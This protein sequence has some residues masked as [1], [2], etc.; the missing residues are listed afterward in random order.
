MAFIIIVALAL[1]VLI[2]TA[3][4]GLIGAPYVPT[5]TRIIEKSLDHLK[6]GPSDVVADLGS[7]DGKVLLAAAQRGAEAFGFELSPIMW[8][9][10]W[11]RTVGNRK[12]KLQYGNFFKQP[13]PN[14]TII[15]IFLMPKTMR[16]L[17][18]YLAK[19]HLPRGKYL[20]SYIFPVPGLTPL[21]IIKEYKSGKIYVYDIQELILRQAPDKP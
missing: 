21:Q 9:I 8:A 16:R 1:I 4:A 17:K 6:V 18:R 14:A 5:K 20:L 15:F 12:I 2:P 19:Q 13:L 10:A 11:V 7:G 3:Y